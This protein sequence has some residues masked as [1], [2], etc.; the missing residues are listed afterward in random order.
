MAFFFPLTPW[1]HLLHYSVLTLLTGSGP[2]AVP[3]SQDFPAGVGPDFARTFVHHTTL[4]NGIKLHY[5]AGGKGPALVLLHGWPY[6]WYVWRK[7]MPALARH[8]TLIVPDLRGTG[9]SE[10]PATG[11]DKHLVAEDIYQLT[12]QLGHAQIN[13]VG[14][15]IGTMV[16]YAYA[17]AHPAGVRR[18]VLS[19][20]SGLPGFGLEDTMDPAHGGYWH[21]GFHM[22]DMAEQLTQGKERFYIEACVRGGFYRPE[23][24]PQADLDEYVRAYAAPGGMRGGFGHYRTLLA[25]AAYNRQAFRQ[26]LPMPVLVLTG[27]HGVPPPLLLASVRRVATQVQAATIADSGHTFMEE[28]P[29]E[30]LRHLQ[31]F[32]GQR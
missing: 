22:Q 3:S 31:A 15:D 11:Y 28:N 1:Q 16:A 7:V 8:Y 12:Q 14:H 20:T 24:V 23:T 9:D 19:E 18:L 25:D 13:L 4:V 32:L 5:V 26:K 27:D 30:T 29:V 21:F 17:N 10:K 2:A 6:T